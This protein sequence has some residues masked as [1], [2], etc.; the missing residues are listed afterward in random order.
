[1]DSLILSEIWIYP[2]KSLG[3]ISLKQWTVKRKGLQFDRRWMLID[4]HGTFMTQR[5]TTQMALFKTELKG[6]TFYISHSGDTV[7]LPLDQEPTG[8][9]C[10]SNV[11]DD[12]V[13][14]I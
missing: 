13:E 4:E 11:W 14:V 10:T 5:N 1:M 8:Q 12:S 6:N 7:S 3:G 2:I 9:T